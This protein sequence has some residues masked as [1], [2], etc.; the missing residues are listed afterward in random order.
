MSAGTFSAYPMGTD[1]CGDWFVTALNAANPALTLDGTLLD[2]G[3]AEFP[4]LRWAGQCWP[5]MTRVG[6][7]WRATHIDGA[8]VVRGDVRQPGQFAP[9][10]F[11]TIVS[12]SAIEHIGLGH[13][14]KDPLDEAG[15]SVA[16]A[17]AL[18]WLKPGGWLYFDVPFSPSG[19]RVVGTSHREYDAAAFVAR[20]PR[21]DGV[22]ETWRGWSPMKEPGTLLTTEPTEPCDP[23]YVMG[24]WWQKN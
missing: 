20:F 2:V 17:N 23:F 9:E 12:L 1:V 18:R 3:C 22:T 13:Y 21:P 11:D 10:T 16:I 4:W 8:R 6:L 7:D 5:A 15:D 24:V 14:N 19:Y